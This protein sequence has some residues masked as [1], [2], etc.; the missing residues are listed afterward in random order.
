MGR[1][2]LLGL[3]IALAAADEITLASGEVID[4]EILVENVDEVRVRIVQGGMSAERA[5]PRSA[6]AK[7]VHGASPRQ[8]DRAALAAE[9]AA[10]PPDA[11]GGEWT[12]LAL[13][14]RALGDQGQVRILAERACARDR[15]QA[16]AQ[17]LLGRDLVNGVWMRPHEA[18]A[19]RGEVWEAGRWMAWTERERLRAE[20]HERAERLR[21]ELAAAADRRRAAA[22]AAAAE[23]QSADYAWPVYTSYP[24]TRVSW[25]GDGYGYGGYG[26]GYGNCG[27]NLV[28]G[29]TG[30]WGNV[31]WRLR[32]NW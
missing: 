9:A 8:R 29:A 22:A 20:A 13:K 28:I 21:A 14:A 5:W 12:R 27:P 6:V 17:R 25:W 10:L 19:A 2:L 11:P 32:L 3:L 30:H 1:S 7:I 26:N 24:N 23:Q 16:E 15:N 4:G 18:A 31:D